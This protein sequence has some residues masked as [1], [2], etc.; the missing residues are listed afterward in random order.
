V[1]VRV[2]PDGQRETFL[3][4]ESLLRQSSAFFE[5]ALKDEWKEASNKVVT[6]TEYKPDDFRVYTKFLYTGLVF[7]VK[8]EDEQDVVGEPATPR[9]QN[10]CHKIN[11]WRSLNSLSDYLQAPNFKDALVDAL[12]EIAAAVPWICA[13]TVIFGASTVDFV[14]Q[15]SPEGS[16]IRRFLVNTKI[17]RNVPKS[18]TRMREYP[19]A[20]LQDILAAT[21]P[22][23]TSTQKASDGQDPLNL[24]RTYWG[25]PCSYQSPLLT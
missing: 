9:I 1:T 17:Y 12:M 4:H 18:Y 14:Y 2:G 16:N 22:L 24:S 25:Y 10:I 3:L 7:M 8:V 6:L 20:F 5:A 19:P 23:I 21:G 11:R 15:H 13:N